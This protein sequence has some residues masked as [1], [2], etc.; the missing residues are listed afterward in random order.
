MKAR[1]LT[2]SFLLAA[3]L[4]GCSES[5]PVPPGPTGVDAPVVDLPARQAT[6]SGL[7]YDPEAFFALYMATPEGEFPSIYDGLSYLT[8][9]AI[10]D[11]TV[12]LY[13]PGL[14]DAT[15]GVSTGAGHWQAPGVTSSDEAPYLAEAVPPSE[16]PVAFYTDE[17]APLVLP[18][19]THYP[20]T[21]LRPIQVSGTQCMSQMA[22]MVGNAGAL[23]AVAQ[24]LSAQQETPT[25]VEDLLDPAKTG[26]VVLFW[27]HFP[28]YYYDFDL[29]TMDSVAG[30]ASAGTLVALDWT[31]PEGLPGQSP[32]G[33]S[34][35]P[36]PVSTV[37]YFALVLPPEL[38]EP[39]TVSFS[40]TYLPE[41]EEEPGEFGE[42]PLPIM[43]IEVT[44]RPGSVSVQRVFADFNFP[45]VEPDPLED[46]PPPGLDESWRCLAPVHDGPPEE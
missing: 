23:D 25:T 37:G 38:T 46:P 1:S 21:H 30:E 33:Y 7:I 42:R 20:T 2:A 11:A 24:H 18:E 40:D 39:V 16:G 5:E 10:P 45:P 43:P 34:V 27:V 12:R 17:F 8:Y 13:A 6:V 14:P 31:M 9:S 22:L 26:G 3:A 36:D 4:G 35:L 15:S 28:S 19:A 32:L 41:P 44:P 29:L